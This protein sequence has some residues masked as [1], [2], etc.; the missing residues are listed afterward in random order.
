MTRINNEMRE[1]IIRDLLTYR[2]WDAANILANVHKDIAARIYDGLYTIAHHEWLAKAPAGALPDVNSISVSIN[3]SFHRFYFSGHPSMIGKYN[4]PRTLAK[5]EDLTHR[6]YKKHENGVA[7][8]FSNE[9]QIGR[10]ILTYDQAS[11]RLNDEIKE[12]YL[13][14]ERTIKRFGSIKS[15]IAAWPEIAPFAKPFDIVVERQLPMVQTADLNKTFK[16]PVPEVNL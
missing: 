12:A 5:G 9:D 11:A 10:D 8:V 2:F 16:L 15:L 14:A 1:K 13:T 3:N 6:V 7:V 4:W